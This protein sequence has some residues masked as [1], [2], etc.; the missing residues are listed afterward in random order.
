MLD[1]N[2]NQH[3]FVSGR[4]INDKQHRYSN[5]DE[6]TSRLSR[7][8]LKSSESTCQ[9]SSYA[10][11]VAQNQTFE[12]NLHPIKSIQKL[13]KREQPNVAWAIKPHPKS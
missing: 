1:S 7:N 5:K 2:I 12:A 8:N 9:E 3:T 10:T 11:L 4:A 13:I 6:F